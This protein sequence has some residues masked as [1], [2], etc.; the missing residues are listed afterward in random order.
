VEVPKDSKKVLLPV[1]G[2]GGDSGEIVPGQSIVFATLEVCLGVLSH[3][4][5]ALNPAVQSTGFHVRA[6]PSNLTEDVCQLLANVVNVLS[7]LQTLCS[8][9]G[10]QIN[11]YLRKQYNLI[12][13]KCNLIHS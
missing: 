9:A 2:E 11:K 4:V 3:R 12:D 6:A 7:E 13:I 5:P 1:G 10:G 8:I